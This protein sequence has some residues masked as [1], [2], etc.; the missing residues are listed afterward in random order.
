MSVIRGQVSISPT[1][2]K[3]LFVCE[4]VLC[5]FS[6]ITLCVRIFLKKAPCKMLVKWTTAW[7][8]EEPGLKWTYFSHIEEV[9]ILKLLNGVDNGAANISKMSVRE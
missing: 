8:W 7:Q 3:Q 4:G 6:V 1:F 9:S 2:Y 5:S